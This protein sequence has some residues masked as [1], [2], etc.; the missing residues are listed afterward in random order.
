MRN[1]CQALVP[2]FFVLLLMAACNTDERKVTDGTD[3]TANK[4]IQPDTGALQVFTLPAPL[5]VATVMRLEE[6][7][8]KTQ[9]LL[10]G[11]PPPNF[12]SNDQRAAALGI[13]LVDMGYACTYDQR[14][15]ALN[16][17]KS[18][19]DIMDDLGITSA[20]N[21]QVAKRIEDNLRNNDSLYSII[22]ESYGTAHNYFRDNHRE[23]TGL[24]IMAGAY[25]EGLNLVL[26]SKRALSNSRL[27]NLV[28]QQK[29]FLENIIKLTD[30]M[31]DKPKVKEL[32]VMLDDLTKAFEG[33]SVEVKDT[34][35]GETAV[36]CSLSP[37]QLRRLTETVGALRKRITAA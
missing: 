34:G 25:I 11:P 37:E 10:P 13:Y 30:Y 32:Q 18:V 5:Q 19:Q 3:T 23:E 21:V 9:Y 20:I 16:Y 28:G 35:D 4:E 14:Q 15:I 26:Q 6:E 1:F 2:G 29:I 22:L 27:R 31:A 12:P 36:N 7:Q 17:A 24:F 8:Y 33:I